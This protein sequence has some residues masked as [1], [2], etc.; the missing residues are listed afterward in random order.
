[1]NYDINQVTGSAVFQSFQSI[2]PQAEPWDSLGYKLEM[3]FGDGSQQF[4]FTQVVL[5][6]CHACAVLGSLTLGFDFD[7]DGRYT[8]VSVLG[9]DP[10]KDA[11]YGALS[12]DLSQKSQYFQTVDLT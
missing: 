1:P 3:V 9:I 6:G 5:N 2:Y 7:R 8:G 4:Q 12:D 11:A 10:E